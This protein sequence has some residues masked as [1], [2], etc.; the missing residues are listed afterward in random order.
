MGNAAAF[1]FVRSAP[2]RFFLLRSSAVPRV[3]GAA[4]QLRQIQPFSSTPA[5]RLRDFFP[6]KDTTRIKTTRPAWPPHS[7]TYEEMTS[8]IPGHREPRGTA[9][10]AAWKVVRFARYCM[11]KATG[12]NR[13]QQVD[14]NN[15]TTSIVAQKPLTEAQWLTRFIFLE[16]I[17]GVPGMVGGMLR[18]LSSLRRMKRDNG[19]IETLLEESYNERM[20]LLTFM[21]MCEPGWFM[22]VMIIGAQGVFFNG[23][24]VCYLFSPKIVHRFVGYLE[25]EAVHTYTRCIKEIEEGHLPKWSDPSFRIPD[26]AIQYWNIPVERQTMKDL[27]LYIR[28]DEAVHRGVNHTLGNLNQNE[29]PN[30]FVSEF[31]DREAPK[32]ALQPSGYERTDVI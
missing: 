21:K 20:H 23:L 28:A 3:T 14:K 19:W 6:A 24:F 32:P 16:S 27:I 13:E 2:L 22:K 29:D 7:Y 11:D 9:D 31:K 4:A 25:E 18:H 1:G 17:A 10:W 5:A 15:P 8:V 12:M 26:I 30:P